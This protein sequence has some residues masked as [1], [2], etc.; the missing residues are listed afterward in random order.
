MVRRQI[1]VRKFLKV[2]SSI[3]S[4]LNFFVSTTSMGNPMGAV[5]VVVVVGLQVDAGTCTSGRQV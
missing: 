3:L 5:V 2:G 1:P 4:G